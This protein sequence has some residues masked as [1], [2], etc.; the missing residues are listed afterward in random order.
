MVWDLFFDF[1]DEGS[2]MTFGGWR[3]VSCGEIIDP[4]IL[5]NRVQPPVLR[6][7]QPRP[8]RRIAPSRVG[9]VYAAF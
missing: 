2:R 1:D 9:A 6:K 5:A 7:R 8:P 4:V 3:C